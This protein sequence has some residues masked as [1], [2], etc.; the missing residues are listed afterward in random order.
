MVKEPVP[1][2][3]KTPGNNEQSPIMEEVEAG[4]SR[5][6]KS[7]EDGTDTGIPKKRK[8]CHP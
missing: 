5:K 4:A 8:V 7:R 2:P 1:A 3:P 6:R